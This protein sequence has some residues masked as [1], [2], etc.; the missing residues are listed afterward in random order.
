MLS[1][2]ARRRYSGWLIVICFAVWFGGTSQPAQGADPQSADM[3][4][5]K[6]VLFSS[7]V[8]FFE[9]SGEVDGDRTIE[10]KFNSAS[11]NDLLKSMVARDLGGGRIAAV[12]YGSREPLAKTLRTF[13]I[14]LTRNPTLADLLRQV[15]GEQVRISAPNATEGLIV[16]VEHRR[17]PAGKDDVV[18]LDVLNLKTATGLR[19]IPLTSVV[20]IRL[21]NVSLDKEFQDALTLM[22]TAHST[23]KKTVSLG[24]TGKGRRPVRVGYIQDSPIWKTSYRLVL[25]DK[26]A[27]FL[28]GWAIVENTTEHDWKDISMTL[29]SGRPVSFIEDLYEP[30]Y[31]DRPVVAPELFGS[32]TPRMHG[33]DM[34]DR[35]AI[36]G[37]AL[38]GA[39]NRSGLPLV[40]SVN[41][42]QTGGGL[43]GAGGMGGFGGGG[44]GGSGMGGSN[45]TNNKNQAPA[46]AGQPAANGPNE[47]SLNLKQGVA[48]A[49][50]ADEVGELF[51]YQIDR[52]VTLARQ[53]SAMLPIVN[54]SVRGEKVSIYNP[55]VD[56]KHPLAGL[57][58]HNTTKMHLMQGPITVFDGGEYAGDSQIEDIAPG[59]SRLISYALDLN[60]EIAPRA[61]SSPEELTAVKIVQGVIHWVKKSNRTQ[62]FVVKNSGDRA[63][64]V[65]IERPIDANWQLVSPK[66][67]AEKTRDLYRF[68]I[69]APPKKSVE[70]VVE[71]EHTNRA[72]VA[73]GGMSGTQIALY[74]SSSAASPAFKAAIAELEKRKV[75]LAA[76]NEQIHQLDSEI[77]GISTEQ[78]R[79]RQNMAQLDKTSPLYSRYVKMFGEQEDQIGKARVQLKDLSAQAARQD[80]ALKDFVQQISVE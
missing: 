53:Q 47:P 60:I 46:A 18:D 24:F 22:A 67:P 76:V 34:S 12:T 13:S 58:F 40:A 75:A 63:K 9:H 43:G 55:E 19:S 49:A 27:P 4:L 5:K 80:K 69:D 57:K 51:R 30:L 35:E 66:T 54:E 73:I 39:A 50:R 11:I 65:L 1:T 8:G 71:E 48:S 78:S 68:A 62:H 38:H 23:D 59:A 14:D 32:L 56:A 44:F 3:P 37:T 79:I 20:E 42:F 70:L 61:V 15:R 77:S 21:M 29:V 74:S 25:D 17:M 36:Q 45:N 33:Q 28:Q 26:E 31:V 41:P 72:E 6:V 64:R 52:P 2:S 7:G 16:S 10:F